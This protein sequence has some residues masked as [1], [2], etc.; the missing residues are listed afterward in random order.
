MRRL[1]GA[2]RFLIVLLVL[3]LL[4]PA[5]AGCGSD[6]NGSTDAVGAVAHAGKGRG[7]ESIEGF[8]E[9]AEGGT[10]GELLGVFHSYLMAVGRGEHGA[11]CRLLAGRVQRALVE[12]AGGRGRAGECPAAMT[13]LLGPMDAAAARREADGTIVKVRVQ[14]DSAFVVFSA[15]GAKLFQMPL[16]RAGDTWKAGIVMPSVLVPSAATLGR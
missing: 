9:E 1:R 11:A 14:D 2:S 3:C 10:R 8:G 5:M 4:P 7:E 16:T 12:F 15:P 13:K 6:K